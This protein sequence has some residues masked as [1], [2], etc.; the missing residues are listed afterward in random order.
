MKP[1][2]HLPAGRP[3]SLEQLN[4]GPCAGTLARKGSNMP[5]ET[6]TQPPSGGLTFVPMEQCICACG[7]DIRPPYLH[8]SIIKH[9]RSQ[10]HPTRQSVKAYCQH[11]QR[12]YLLT[13]VLSGGLWQTES[14]PIEVTDA[15]RKAEFVASLDRLNGNVQVQVRNRRRVAVA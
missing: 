4:H 9:A 11:C 1:R 10:I 5:E 14:G 8:A 6:A 12:L 7:E 3:L 13:R 15:R 2:L